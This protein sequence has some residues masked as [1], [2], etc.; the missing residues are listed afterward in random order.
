MTQFSLLSG[1]ASNRAS[2]TAR[3]W[4]AIVCAEGPKKDVGRLVAHLPTAL[5]LLNRANG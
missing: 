3:S 1:W 5:R 2:E 4:I